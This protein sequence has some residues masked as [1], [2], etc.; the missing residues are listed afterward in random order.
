M[1]LLDTLKNTFVEQVEVEDKPKQN[2]HF[3]PNMSVPSTTSI[4]GGTSVPNL[5]PSIPTVDQEAI[6]ALDEKSKVKFQAAITAKNPKFYFKLNDLLSTLAEDTPN[7]G[8][9]YK[10]AIKLLIKEGA[11]ASLLI[12]D[13]DLCI[14]A[15]DE[16]NKNFSES[17]N[18]KLNERIGSRQNNIATIDQTLAQKQQQ[19]QALQAEITTL[20]NQKQVE[21]NAIGEET[22]KINLSKERFVVVYNELHTQLQKQKD[23]IVNYSK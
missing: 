6:K 5:Q 17:V 13:I 2:V 10:M 18:Q 11:T 9:V 4:L 8:T 14:A 23:N 21:A 22:Q 12:S 1:S 20:T 3:I 16:N 7:E 19:I 15:I